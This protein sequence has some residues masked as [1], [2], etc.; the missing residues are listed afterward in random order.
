MIRESINAGFVSIL[1]TSLSCT[2]NAASS[3][4]LSCSTSFSQKVTA[5]Y[6]VYGPDNGNIPSLNSF[7]FQDD[8]QCEKE[9]R[10]AKC[11]PI[12]AAV[13]PGD[14]EDWFLQVGIFNPLPNWAFLFIALIFGIVI[15]LVLYKI[16]VRDRIIKRN[17]WRNTHASDGNEMH[18]AAYGSQAQEQDMQQG[19]KNK[20]SWGSDSWQYPSSSSRRERKM[21][22]TSFE[23]QNKKKESATYPI[24]YPERYV[25]NSAQQVNLPHSSQSQNEH[26]LISIYSLEGT[27][28]P[29]RDS[30][31]R[32]SSR[33]SSRLSQ[34][35]SIRPPRFRPP[36]APLPR[37]PINIVT[38]A[39]GGMTTRLQ[40]KLGESPDGQTGEGGARKKSPVKLRY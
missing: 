7:S 1:I 11:S 6:T 10:N 8:Q 31:I 21:S 37:L 35:S 39:G 18:Y 34:S 36:D 24:R 9:T 30:S 12:T 5:F 28:D 14:D 15:I 3:H 16:L 40:K 29:D 17:V 38:G 20:N 4:L 19:Q 23:N 2:S 33:S 32:G 13:K 25:A 27:S 26:D 22:N